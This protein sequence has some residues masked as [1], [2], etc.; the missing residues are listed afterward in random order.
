M[1]ACNYFKL[2][3]EKYPCKRL[4]QLDNRYRTKYKMSM[5]E[6]LE[7]IKKIGLDGFIESENSRWTCPGCGSMLCV[8][9][10]FCLKCKR[11]MNN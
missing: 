4:K 11:L 7:L 10:D 2:D 3:C 8:H 1:S 5:I 9:R 6:N